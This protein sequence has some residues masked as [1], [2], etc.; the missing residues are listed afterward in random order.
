[1]GM[2]IGLSLSTTILYNAMSSKAGYRVTGYIAGQDNLFL[3]GMHIAFIVSFLLCFIAFLVT[4][5]RLFR[6]RKVQ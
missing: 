5:F 3:Y 2:V 6:K 4:G 1:L